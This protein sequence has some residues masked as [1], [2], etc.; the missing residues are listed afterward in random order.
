MSARTS[1][2]DAQII[3]E[4]AFGEPR[5]KMSAARKYSIAECS[6]INKIVH[7]DILLA[8]KS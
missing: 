4:D 1:K 3:Y 7:L 8:I 2:P 5:T 6:D